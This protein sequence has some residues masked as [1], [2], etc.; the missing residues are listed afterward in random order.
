M[1]IFQCLNCGKDIFLQSGKKEVKFCSNE[2]Y[3]LKRKEIGTNECAKLK[4]IFLREE[5]RSHKPKPEHVPEDVG[6]K[7][8]WEDLSL[9]QLREILEDLLIENEHLRLK[10]DTL[11]NVVR[12]FV[13]DVEALYPVEPVPAEPP[14]QEPPLPDPGPEPS[15]SSPTQTCAGI[16]C[17]NP[18]EPDK[19]FCSDQC[20]K[21]VLP[22]HGRMLMNDGRVIA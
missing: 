8:G 11:I 14:L 15:L 4:P 19:I 13:K 7:I 17:K 10:Q 3:K 16:G 20:A 5:S 1:K 12:G 22:K 21:S 18:V 6:E 9:N 2:C